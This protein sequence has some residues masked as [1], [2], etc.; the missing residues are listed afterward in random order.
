MNAQYPKIAQKEGH[1]DRESKN[2]KAGFLY[3]ESLVY[4]T[5]VP[6]SVEIGFVEIR[7]QGGTERA[8]EDDGGTRWK[9]KATCELGV[10]YHIGLV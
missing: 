3:I 1:I 6:R 8:G 9:E 4:K 5:R 7:G 10:F 2:L